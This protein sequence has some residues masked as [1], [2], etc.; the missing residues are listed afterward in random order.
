MPVGFLHC[1]VV[2]EWEHP[3]GELL[4]GTHGLD[5]F[6]GEQKAV[7]RGIGSAALNGA[8]ALLMSR[9]REGG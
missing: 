6:I 1:Y 5:L 7:G 4:P 9:R 2:D 8:R 3:F